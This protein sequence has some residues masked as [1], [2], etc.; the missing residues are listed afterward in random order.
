MRWTRGYDLP[1]ARW[2]RLS[3]ICVAPLVGAPSRWC[4]ACF[5]WS[6]GAASFGRRF[7]IRTN[8]PELFGLL[9]GLLPPLAVPST[10]ASF[11]RTFSLRRPGLCPCGAQHGSATLFGGR[12]L[13]FRGP[14][15]ALAGQ[16]LRTEH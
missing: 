12:Q 9:P 13:L 5:E 6:Q 15:I 8:D 14:D 1:N 7:L 10:A 3:L 4:S 11:D 16:R 2:T